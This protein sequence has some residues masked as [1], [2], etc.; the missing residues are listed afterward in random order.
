MFI[1]QIVEGDLQ[2]TIKQMT[3]DTKAMVF[4]KLQNIVKA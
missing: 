1:I 4:E 3:E 2:A